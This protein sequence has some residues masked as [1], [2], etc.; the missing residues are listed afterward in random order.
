[1]YNK[2]SSFEERP[3][4]SSVPGEEGQKKDDTGEEE[5]RGAGRKGFWPLHFFLGKFKYIFWMSRKGAG[6]LLTH[7]HEA[8]R[9]YREILR[10]S[11]LFNNT[12]NA[13]GQNMGKLIRESARKEFEQGRYET[14]PEIIAKMIISGRD[15]LMQVHERIMKKEQ[16]V[17][18]GPIPPQ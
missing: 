14:N 17:D 10:S 9:L 4:S 12:R 7:K 16:G 11:K 15:C 8:L 6:E 2:T 3:A 13:Q 1:V 5:K 18:R